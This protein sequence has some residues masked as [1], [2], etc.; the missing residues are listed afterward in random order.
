[1][2][3]FLG[4]YYSNVTFMNV[5]L[6]L[7]NPTSLYITSGAWFMENDIT[8]SFVG[9]E[10]WVIGVSGVWLILCTKLARNFNL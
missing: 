7:L 4:A 8:L 2:A 10:F 5:I 6:H 1:M 9:N 3:L